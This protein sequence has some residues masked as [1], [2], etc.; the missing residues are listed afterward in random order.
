MD[1]LLLIPYHA[2]QAFNTWGE[3][4]YICF[5]PN[6][7]LSSLIVFCSPFFMP[8]LFLLAG[9]C[10]RYA[11]KKR[12]YKQFL[13]ERAKRLLVPLLFGALVFCPI[14]SYMGDKTN[15]GYSGGFFA[16]YPIFFSKWTDLTG[17]DG[18][19]TV[20]Q[21][22]FLLYLFVIS[23]ATLA[24]IALIRRIRKSELRD[25]NVPFWAVCLLVI[26]LPFL[27]D[28][29]S[30]GGKSFVEYLFLFLLGYF[31]LSN[32]QVLEK[33]EKFRYVTLAI[34]LFACIADVWMFLW[35]GKDFG[36]WNTIAKAFAEWF[37]ILALLGIGKRRLDF[38]GKVSASMS[39]RSFPYF[40]FHFLWVVL[41]QYWFSNLFGGSTALLYF[42]P[43]VCA[44]LAT[45][46]CTEV[47][48][49]IP[50]FCFLLGTKNNN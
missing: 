17:F 47:S 10:T 35:S 21:F 6:K 41:F 12:T 8:L 16:H 25:W 32:D 22:W 13:V 39:Q 14:L 33:A 4:N 23:M 19:F 36:I 34:G 2:A 27:Y 15:Y 48:I 45:A 7:V 24:L 43:V 11:L 37:M 26:P 29:L 20:G 3:L 40:S 49:R 9:M 44:F 28:L 42:V 50:A 31:V 38:T 5:A 46:I 18:G 30:V 1:V